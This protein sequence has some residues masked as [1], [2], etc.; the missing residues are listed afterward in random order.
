[1]TEVVQEP[2]ELL[3]TLASQ[4]VQVSVERGR[5]RL[6]GPQALLGEAFSRLNGQREA[7]IALL[8]ASDE[9]TADAPAQLEGPTLGSEWPFLHLGEALAHAAAGDRGVVLF[10]SGAAQ[11][12]GWSQLM[13][14]ALALL[15][16]WQDQ[17]VRPGDPVLLALGQM[18]SGLVC[19]WAGLLGDL[20]VVPVAMGGGSHDDE[21][22]VQL[23]KTLD[24][25]RKSVWWVA[26]HVSM[27]TAQFPIGRALAS[28]VSELPGSI[29]EWRP[30]SQD[31]RRPALLLPGDDGQWVV[32]SHREILGRVAAVATALQCEGTDSLFNPVALHRPG[33]LLHVHFLAVV[34]G[35]EFYQ[36]DEAL[37]AAD[38]LHFL[39][40][41][42]DLAIT[43]G[44]APASLWQRLPVALETATDS[45]REELSLALVRRLVLDVGTGSAPLAPL[46]PALSALGL[47]AAGLVPALGMGSPLGV[48]FNSAGEADERRGPGVPVV[49]AAVRVVAPDGTLVQWGQRGLLQ[50]R[51][52][53]SSR[54][55]WLDAWRPVGWR[56]TGHV[57]LVDARGVSLLGWQGVSVASVPDHPAQVEPE[58]ITVAQVASALAEISQ[59]ESLPVEPVEMPAEVLV[60][61]P[62]DVSVA[63]VQC[64]L[65]LGI[66]AA[67]GGGADVITGQQ[68][69]LAPGQGL[70]GRLQVLA[71]QRPRDVA[72]LQDTQFVRYH[73]LVQQI[74]QWAAS[75]RG[76]GVQV[77]DR[78]VLAMPRGA[79][80]IASLFALW[81]IGAV[82]VPVDIEED[83]DHVTAV[84]ASVRP[85]LVL[86]HDTLMHGDA[87]ARWG[88]LCEDQCPRLGLKELPPA[89][90]LRDDTA[91]RFDSL[92]CIFYARDGSAVHG[93]CYTHGDLLVQ[94]Q[95]LAA[96]LNL[97]ANARWLA[98]SDPGRAQGVLESLMPLLAGATLVVP[99]GSVLTPERLLQPLREQAVTHVMLGAD[100]LR[101]ALD[102]GA[103]ARGVTVLAHGVRDQSVCSD[104]QAVGARGLALALLPGVALCAAMQPLS[105]TVI[106]RGLLGEP[107]FNLG[108]AILSSE[109]QAAVTSGRGEWIIR[110]DGVA[111]GFWHDDD[112]QA[113][114]FVTL[115]GERYLRTGV[116][117]VLASASAGSGPALRLA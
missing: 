37:L 11:R 79:E 88:R 107:L 110:G 75:L 16:Q 17:G 50:W 89:P 97:R 99:A 53:L 31:S 21:A 49:G 41:L 70:Y 29:G 13:R 103:L 15:A 2:R 94:F 116:E 58:E 40:L 105:P 12:L 113:S 71:R 56:H 63:P 14:E 24:G 115:N 42:D 104:M 47:E 90:H 25:I 101:A 74:E 84:L 5:I 9:P 26:D 87:G 106:E 80:A 6:K 45:Q 83:D 69:R 55:D 108:F 52:P 114:R 51:S 76:S 93:A 33:A 92:A 98:T 43:L 10:E 67:P 85:R 68:V 4:G 95:S 73:G 66:D 8:S 72:I 60:D 46:L 109:G 3:E 19:L 78:I 38:G 62:P 82:V 34:Q 91:P 61:L 23:W 39:R 111:Q 117:V 7:V 86:C 22:G 18:R 102:A 64:P 59:Q 65:P 48:L 81:R 96:V 30:V 32:L 77:A 20:L 1:M 112:Y 100:W 28:E 57:A 27:K 44:W 36:A 54:G 35:L